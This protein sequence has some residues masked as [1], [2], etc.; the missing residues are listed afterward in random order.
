[1]KVCDVNNVRQTEM[2]TAEPLIP[3]PSSFMVEIAIEKLKRYKYQVLIKF[4]QNWSKQEVI[5]YIP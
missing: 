2:H 1:M 5:H 4:Q 3:K